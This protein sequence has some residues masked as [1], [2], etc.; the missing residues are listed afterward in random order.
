MFLEK[1]LPEIIKIKID[2]LKYG[3][4]FKPY[5]L[6]TNY[7]NINNF[8]TKKIKTLPTIIEKTVFDISKDINL[9]PS[10]ILLKSNDY[11]SIV[12]LRYSQTSPIKMVIENN[13][14][15]LY[16]NNTP[17]DVEVSLVKKLKILEEKTPLSLENNNTFINDFIDIVGI[18]RISILLFEGCYNWICRKACKFCDLHPKMKS[19]RVIKPSLNDL[20]KFNNDIAKWWL[21]KKDFYLEGL[22]YSLRE[23]L[24]ATNNKHNHLY[25]MA[26]NLP[27][28]TETWKIAIDVTKAISDILSSNTLDT[29][30]N[31]APH[32]D[33]NNLKIIKN[34]GINQVQYNLE[35]ANKDLFSDICPGKMDYDSFVKKL[36]EAVKI[37]G[38]GNVRTNF[39]LGLQDMN[40]LLFEI[41]KLAKLGI[42]SDY[43]VFQ[44]KKNT[45][46]SYKKAPNFDDIIDF[47]IELSKIYKKYSFKPIFCSLSSRSSIVNEV[48]DFDI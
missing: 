45:P 30:L 42:V 3:I 21:S 38:Q 16:K 24:K 43:S 5:N 39:V 36:I 37:F 35:V 4:N 40:E 44:P 1:K 2:I 28:N 22:N 10:E 19:E 47:T 14:L 34:L 32:D 15:K 33:I 13:K 31:I 29:Y 46:F 9:I 7:N 11:K 23:I 27:T 18:D 41:E 25:L 6:F 26:G 48:F 20:Y 17:L 8:K 12:K